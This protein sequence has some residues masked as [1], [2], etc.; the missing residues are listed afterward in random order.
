MKKLC[1]TE[2]LGGQT[3]DHLLPIRSDELKRILCLMLKNADENRSVDV[4]GELLR[5]ANNIVS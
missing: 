5:L 4:E 1:M 2:L 3:L